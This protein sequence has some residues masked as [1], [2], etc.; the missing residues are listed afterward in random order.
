LRIPSLSSNY[1][2][3]TQHTSPVNKF[4][5]EQTEITIQFIQSNNSTDFEKSVT[6]EPVGR[7]VYEMFASPSGDYQK[8]AHKCLSSD[9]SID[10][11][12]YSSQRD[13]IPYSDTDQLHNQTERP[14]PTQSSELQ[15]N[16]PVQSSR[17]KQQPSPSS[18]QRDAQIFRST[19]LGGNG[20]HMQ[21][22]A[23]SVE[24]IESFASPISELEV[25]LISST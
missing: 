8:P 25:H 7:A 20:N 2:S 16:G 18:V 1:S 21:V 10:T 17:D 23:S 5:R 15:K 12:R 19:S 13:T 9:E 22:G 24:V 14:A 4:L 6:E 11:R 3:P